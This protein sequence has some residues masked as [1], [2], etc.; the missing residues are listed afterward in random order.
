MSS[1]SS[2]RPLILRVASTR[3]RALRLGLRYGTYLL[4]L[5]LCLVVAVVSPDFAT[6]GNL[7]NVLLQATHVG[8]VAVGVTFVILVRGIDVSVGGTLALASGVA[9]TAMVVDGQPAIVGLALIIGVG[10]LVGF[11]NGFSTAKLGM[12]SFLVTLATLTI[13]RGLVLA[14][15]AGRSVS[16]L[17]DLFVAIGRGYVGPMPVSV[18]VMFA[19]FVVGH[20]VLSKT[21]FGRQIY[22][23]GGNPEAA[24]VSGI[25]VERIVLLA[26]VISGLTAGLGSLVLTSRFDAFT[27]SMGSGLEFSAIAAVVIGG[28]SLYGGRGTIPGTLVG[29]LTIGVINNALNLLGVSAFYQDVVRGAVIFL[30]V[31][32][33]TLRTR[34]AASILD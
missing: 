23:V 22:A 1:G 9:V 3:Q 34:Y 2:V 26:F 25:K 31:L 15:S 21:I 12:P 5:G 30:A 24:R 6:V 17:P 29:V 7:T 20:V 8:I 32:L 28:T 33:D 19:V 10:I 27:A 14:I 18:L 16:G 13:A 11:V 4:F